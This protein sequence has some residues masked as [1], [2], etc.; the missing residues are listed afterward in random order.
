MAGSKISTANKT[1]LA[2]LDR[3]PPHV[4][5]NIVGFGSTFKTLFPSVV[6]AAQLE[7]IERAREACLSTAADLG[8]TGTFT[9]HHL[10]GVKWVAPFS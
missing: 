1:L 8:G 9:N 10:K 4:H 2:L 6:S 5:F 3:L 7:H